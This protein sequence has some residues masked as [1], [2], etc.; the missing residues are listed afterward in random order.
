[1]TDR[2]AVEPNVPPKNVLR[3][4]NPVMRVLLRSPAHRLASGKFMLLILTGRR[5]GRTYTIPVGRFDEGGELVVYAAGA[6]RLNLRGGADV[7]VVV[8]GRE[9]A[10]HATFEEDPEAVAR[11]YQATVAR[12]G[13][14]KA[15]MVGLKV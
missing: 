11:Q 4:L 12:L 2:P 15:N 5:S 10:G 8:D 7:R 1:M 6:W 13:Y 14:K 3:V 9:R